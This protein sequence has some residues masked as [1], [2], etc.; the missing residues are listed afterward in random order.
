[1]RESEGSSEAFYGFV[2]EDRSVV[3]ISSK[4]VPKGTKMLDDGGWG[5]VELGS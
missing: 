5:E 2:V 1:M 4:V 3:E